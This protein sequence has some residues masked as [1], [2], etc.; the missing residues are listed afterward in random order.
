[1]DSLPR[2]DGA[3]AV[4]HD[5]AASWHDYDRIASTLV[6]ARPAGLLVHAAGPT[7]DGFRTIDIWVSETAWQRDRG[8]WSAPFHGLA[9]P[10]VAREF[11]ILHLITGE[12]VT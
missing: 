8:R 10:P 5:V 6:E 11:R 7:D 9:A 3:F 4:V 2:P 1:V 12:R